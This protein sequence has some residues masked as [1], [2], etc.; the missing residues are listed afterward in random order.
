[1]RAASSALLVPAMGLA[2]GEGASDAAGKEGADRTSS[3]EGEAAVVLLG[4]VEAG[5]TGEP[6]RRK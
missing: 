3:G 4:V 6:N 5:T 2:D 1:M